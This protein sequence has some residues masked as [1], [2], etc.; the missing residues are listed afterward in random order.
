MAAVENIERF[1][2]LLW[3]EA[4][5]DV[6]L[7][8]NYAISV[9]VVV[10]IICICWV[11]GAEIDHRPQLQLRGLIERFEPFYLVKTF[12]LLLLLSET[13]NL[14]ACVGIID[15]VW[16]SKL[17][18]H[19]Q[20]PLLRW[21]EAHRWA[22]PQNFTV[23]ETALSTWGMAHHLQMVVSRPSL[24]GE[25]FILRS[26]GFLGDGAQDGLARAF[27]DDGLLASDLLLQTSK[28]LLRHLLASEVHLCRQI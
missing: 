5:Q 6:C 4:F 8:R 13:A 2:L 12:R 26:A 28:V 3:L 10:A 1:R 17:Q 15:I 20:G 19:S 27:E 16:F 22:W 11:A 25:F 9:A 23:L 18:G 21:L 24:F 14:N 7:L